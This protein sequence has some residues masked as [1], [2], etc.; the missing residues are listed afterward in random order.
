MATRSINEN[1]KL[2][3]NNW[4]G[5]KLAIE[6][7]GVSTLN[8]TTTEYPDLIR[9]ISG[10][11]AVLQEVNI[12]P[13]T[14]E[15][16]I[17]P[18]EGV[19]GF[20]KINVSAVENV[21]SEIIKKGEVILGVIG[22]YSGEGATYQSKEVDPTT[23]EQNISADVGYDALSNVKVKA[24]TATIDSNII[25]SNI[26]KDVEILGVTGTYEEIFSTEEKI[27]NASKEEDVVVTP[28]SGKDGLSKVTVNKVNATIDNNITAE[29]IKKNVTI[30]GVTGTLEEGGNFKGWIKEGELLAT[31]PVTTQCRSLVVNDEGIFIVGNKY[32]YKY[33]E[34]TDTYTLVNESNLFRPL[35][36]DAQAN[37]IN[38]ASGNKNR[39]YGVYKDSNDGNKGL[40]WSYDDLHG[41][42]GNENLQIIQGYMSDAVCNDN[43]MY[44]YDINNKYLRRYDI[45]ANDH[46]TVE[47][48]MQSNLDNTN[49]RPLE[50]FNGDVYTFDKTKLYRFNLSNNTFEEVGDIPDFT[51]EVDKVSYASILAFDNK[52]YILGGKEPYDTYV[53]VY[54]GTT[55]NSLGSKIPSCISSRVKYYNGDVYMLGSGTNYTL[56][57]KIYT[58]GKVLNIK[59]SN[60]NVTYK[61]DIGFNIVNVKAVKS[62]GHCTP[63]HKDAAPEKNY[64]RVTTF[65]NVDNRRAIYF[66]DQVHVFLDKKHWIF[67]EETESLINEETV[68]ALDGAMDWN[69]MPVIDDAGEYMYLMSYANWSGFGYLVRYDGTTFERI[70]AQDKPLGEILYKDG[71]IYVNK[72]SNYYTIDVTDGTKGADTSKDSSISWM[73]SFVKDGK[74][75]NVATGAKDVYEID[76]ATMTQSV[77]MTLPYD[78]FKSTFYIDNKKEWIYT[79]LGPLNND[80]LIR[81]K[82][83]G[84]V[85][86]IGTGYSIGTNYGGR[87]MCTIVTDKKVW[88]LWYFMEQMAVLSIGKNVIAVPKDATR[89]Y[90]GCTESDVKVTESGD[91]AILEIP[92]D[93]NYLVYDDNNVYGFNIVKDKVLTASGLKLNGVEQSGGLV[94][95][96][97]YDYYIMER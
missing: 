20:N 48:V 18:S 95:V 44:M 74:I 21:R 69:Y 16:I 11:S 39:I 29:N 63:K 27:V 8:K 81:F 68:A 7:K 72:G 53:R 9:S 76:I 38:F 70:G 47:Q 28:T 24:V 64:R 56:L 73:Y 58:S 57:Y 61:D 87:F 30:L 4:N 54:D 66:K 86:E 6:E 52:L 25:A 46:T 41:L 22:N 88:L 50:I 80:H 75:Y 35:N 23:S 33:D 45:I 93:A 1:L 83:T 94:N 3:K 71:L 65:N 97:S 79:T 43:S 31:S 85:E 32:L 90:E 92:E 37:V 60:E 17:E 42:V 10:G 59:P 51:S 82:I 36:S 77:V 19:D 89:L 40:I 15:Q 55:I 5:V 96:S 62:V 67:D 78:S 84:E 49:Y 13:S 34:V 26:K 14:S 2:N 91:L 12:T